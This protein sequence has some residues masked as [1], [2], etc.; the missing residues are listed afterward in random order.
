MDKD[1]ESILAS[2]YLKVPRFQRPYSWDKGNV[3]E[4][5]NDTIVEPSDDYFIGSVVFYRDR[6]D[7]FGIV[8]GQQR[9][10]TITLLLCALR[11]AFAGAGLENLARGIHSLIERADRSNQMQYVLQTETSYPYFHEFI[12]K[13]GAPDYASEVGE[14]EVRLEEAF[15][16]ITEQITTVTDSING[17][18]T[19]RKDVKRRRLET[20]LEEI[21]DRVLKLKLIVIELDNEDDAY[22]IFETLN[23]RGK[24]EK[25]SL[26]IIDPGPT[27]V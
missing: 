17:D 16:Y 14:E 15:R 19:L 27:P 7:T 9:L 5:F 12:Q 18:E 20:R 24:A 11:N 25:G 6:S 4:F 8:D 13:Y 10:T 23:T 1:V 3:A 22:L 2:A 21:R 26:L